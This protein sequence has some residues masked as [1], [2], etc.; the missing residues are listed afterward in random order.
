MTQDLENLL[1]VVRGKEE[2]EY[3]IFQEEYFSHILFAGGINEI[4]MK[5]RAYFKAVPGDRYQ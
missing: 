2:K 1:R 3:L 4:P 5:E